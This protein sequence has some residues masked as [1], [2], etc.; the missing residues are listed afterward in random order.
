MSDDLRPIGAGLER[1]LRDMGIPRLFDVVRLAD[2]WVEA[3]GEP[4]ASLARPV[5]YRDGELILEVADGSAASLLKFRVGDL[6]ARLA[7]RYGPG[8][9]T[10]VRIRVGGG[11]KGL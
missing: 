7:E 9:V 11:K 6:V 10:S 3:A 5:G 8:T 4:F 1:L 2:E